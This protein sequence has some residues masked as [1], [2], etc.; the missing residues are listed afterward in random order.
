MARLSQ[1]LLC[2]VL[3]INVSFKICG[4][5]ILGFFITHIQYTEYLFNKNKKISNRTWLLKATDVWSV[6]TTDVLSQQ[7]FCHFR[8]LS[9]V[10]FSFQMFRGDIMSP[11]ILA[12]DVLSVNPTTTTTIQIV[13]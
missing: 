11:N 12:L 13:Y 9:L 5:V 1:N 3:K 2:Y 4:K 8:C 10:V 6:V 7:R